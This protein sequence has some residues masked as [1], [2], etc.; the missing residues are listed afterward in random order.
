MATTMASGTFAYEVA[1]GWG[2]LPEGW[3][4]KEVAAVAVDSNDRVYVFSRG[5]HPMIV[6]D[7]EGNFLQSWGEGLFT[8]AHG[9]TMG[10]TRQSTARM[11]A[12]TP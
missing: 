12:I 1:E 4:Y 10:P 9:L 5:Q 8:R 3:S 11:T 7:R 6:F 2:K